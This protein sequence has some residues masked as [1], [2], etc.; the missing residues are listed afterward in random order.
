MIGFRRRMSVVHKP[1]FFT[2]ASNARGLKDLTWHGVTL[3]PPVWDDPNGRAVS[4]TMAGFGDESDLHVMLN[5]HWDSLDFE[6][7]AVAGRQWHLAIDTDAQAPGDIVEP[8]LERPV[9]GAT[10]RVAGRSVVAL[11]SR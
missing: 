11:I 3:G 7:P 1:R 5:M 10:L 4:F 2:G 9:V 8:G 6:L